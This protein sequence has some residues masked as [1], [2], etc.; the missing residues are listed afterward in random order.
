LEYTALGK[1]GLKVSVAGLGC[2]G[3]S[4]IG[5]GTGLSTAQS[6]ALVREAIDL[7]ITFIDTAEAYGTE[8]I[9]GEAIAPLERSSVV[10]STKS[11][12]GRRDGTPLSAA[13]VVANLDAS[14][15]RLR[16]D[17]V[18]VFLLHG[19]QPS[20]YDRARQEL[21]P[22]LLREK[23]K[24]KLRHLGLSEQAALDHEHT[25]LQRAL[26]D[27]VWEV[28]MFAFHMLN[29]A[30][31]T[32]VFPQTRA[33]GVGTLL[34]FVVRNIFSRPGLLAETMK[35]LAAEGKVPAEFADKRDP[36]DFLVHAGGAESLTDAAYRFARHAPGSEVVLFG[37]GNR[38]HLRSNIESILRPPLPAADVE[39]LHTLFGSLRGVGLDLPDRAQ[40]RR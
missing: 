3:N 7:G 16:T 27:P 10:I 37:T 20:A 36:L 15:R 32:K 17:H 24:G 30:P 14:L 23:D 28:V 35:R 34:M 38:A 40:R 31:R 25:M 11:R 19:V 39:Q 6:V 5:L 21:A 1:T 4:Q 22:A 18:D 29:Q 13:D 2:G 9:V 8:E 12:I 33:R 26:A